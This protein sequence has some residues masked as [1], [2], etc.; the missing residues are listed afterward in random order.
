VS[1]AGSTISR[2]R[3]KH[4]RRNFPDVPFSRHAGAIVLFA[5]Q[6]STLPG[7]FGTEKTGCYPGNNIYS[8]VMK[9]RKDESLPRVPPEIPGRDDLTP[10]DAE[11]LL[12]DE[13]IEEC[14]I[15]EMDISGRKITSL[16]AWDSVFDHVSFASSRIAKF[17]LRDVRLIKCDLSNA[18]LPGF[19]AT[20]VEFI[21]CRM[22][23]MRAVECRWK[24]I[25]VENCD[26][27]YAQFSNGQIRSSEFKSCNF[28]DAD[29]RAANLE[30]AIFNN[31]MLH[32]ADFSKARLQG[33]DLR[34]AEIEGISV[35]PE[36]LRGAIVNVAQAIDLA[37]LLGLIIR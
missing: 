23:G 10:V 20:R 14:L 2:G 1:S 33:T 27:R 18:V 22:T 8:A 32:R 12:A 15:Q 9:R 6:G 3:Q 28:G 25:L 21:D 31:A 16:I 11:K 17:R 5:S 24:D 26:M 13:P 36:D 34:G 19:E 4:S 29:L 7:L 37:R 35:Q 30:G